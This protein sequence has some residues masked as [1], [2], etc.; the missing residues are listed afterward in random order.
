MRLSPSEQDEH[1]LIA[2]YA[3]P[4]AGVPSSASYD[5]AADNGGGGG[6]LDGVAAGVAGTS[7]GGGGA[8]GLKNSKGDGVEGG[9]ADKRERERERRRENISNSRTGR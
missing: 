1:V 9:I 5:S 2:I 4:S 6:D 7:T 8:A 3:R